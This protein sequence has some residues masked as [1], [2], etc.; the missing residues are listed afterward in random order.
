MPTPSKSWLGAIAGGLLAAG[1]SV[2]ACGD[3]PATT[4]SPPPDAAPRAVTVPPAD[5]APG[6]ADAAD[7]GDATDAAP[8]A[9]PTRFVLLGDFGFDDANELAVAALVKSG[10]RLHRHARRQQLPRE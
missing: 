10:P 3:D 9:K 8:H 7:G 4:D 5:G 2:A 6:P 1:L